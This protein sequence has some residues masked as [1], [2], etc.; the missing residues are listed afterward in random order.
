MTCFNLKDRNRSLENTFRKPQ[1]PDSARRDWVYIVI[2]IVCVVPA[3][4]YLIALLIEKFV[5]IP[6]LDATWESPCNSLVENGNT[7]GLGHIFNLDLVYG[8]ITFPMAK[9]ADTTWD[10]GFG[11]GGQALLTWIAYNVIKESVN[12]IMESQPVTYRFFVNTVMSPIGFT[13]LSPL[14]SFVFSRTS[15]HHKLLAIWMT[16]AVIWVLLFPSIAG[17]MTGYVNRVNP[18]TG[19][20]VKLQDTG[21]YLNLTD[22]LGK[23]E[24]VFKYESGQIPP[25]VLPQ[26]YGVD[27]TTVITDD[28]ANSELWKGLNHT[29]HKRPDFSSFEPATLWYCPSMN[30]SSTCTEGDFGAVFLY[31]RYVNNATYQW[32]YT[33][34]IDNVL[35]IQELG[36]QWGFSSVLTSIFLGCNTA[37]IVG[38]AVTWRGLLS[39]SEFTKKRRTMGKYRATVDLA[40]AIKEELGSNLCVLSDAA[41]ERELKERAAIR[42]HVHAETEE[43]HLHIGLSSINPQGHEVRLEYDKLYV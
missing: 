28:G 41:L 1:K 27:E 23:G 34:S 30:I 40:E 13:S 10:I 24:I 14:G 35:C 17:A 12:W 2:P 15:V 39:Q 38:M 21:D 18:D 19:T 33:S 11:R 26:K 7:G 31:L 32:N 8:D 36:Y 6:R 43:T 25:A 5:A 4:V 42:Y 16:I 9:F 22:F 20:M 29:L 37:W 3:A